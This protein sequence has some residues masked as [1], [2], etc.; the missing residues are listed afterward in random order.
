[1]RFC[2]CFLLTILTLAGATKGKTDTNCVDVP[3][4]TARKR[5]AAVPVK[6]LELSD[7][8]SKELSGVLFGVSLTEALELKLNFEAA[9]E[10]GATQL[11]KMVQVLMSAQQLKSEPGETIG[12]DLPRAMKVQKT[13][14]MLRTTV[15][16]TDA[17][18]EKLLEARYGRKLVSEALARLVYVHGLPG[19]TRSFAFG[20][21]VNI[22]L[23][24]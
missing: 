5:P 1:M 12:I 8:M 24:R 11:E 22:D 4:V 19:G 3:R 16:L 17:Q 23:R 9:T 14:K 6:K 7:A 10:E 18:L 15:S 21:S 2:F 13:G 20:D